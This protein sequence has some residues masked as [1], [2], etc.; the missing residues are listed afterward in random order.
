MI[1]RHHGADGG[2]MKMRWWVSKRPGTWKIYD[3]E[4]LDVGLRFST[5]VNALAQMGLA[6]VQEASRAVQDVSEALLAVAVQHDPD[7]ADRKLQQSANVKLPAKA[8]ALRL[9]TTGLVR[10]HRQQF[11]CPILG[12]L[13]HLPA[14]LIQHVRHGSPSSRE[15]AE[16]RVRRRE[17][18]SPRRGRG[19]INRCI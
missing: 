8:E 4:D 17:L 1:V 19:H 5:N 6:N 12:S 14:P 10:L 2:T 11:G 7:A 13:C 15:K 3:F 18:A 9:L 16:A